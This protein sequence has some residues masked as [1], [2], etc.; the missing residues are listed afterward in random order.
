M[1]A[2]LHVWLLSTWNV[3][4]QNE[5]AVTIKWILDFQ[6]LVWKKY[7]NSLNNLLYYVLNC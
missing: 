3:A 7:V 2:I 4:G 6:D 5:M 1:L